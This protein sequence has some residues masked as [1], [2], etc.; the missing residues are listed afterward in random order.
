V[1][2]SSAFIKLLKNEVTDMAIRDIN[3]KPKRRKTWLDQQILY[4]N[5]SGKRGKPVYKKMYYEVCAVCMSS[6]IN[7]DKEQTVCSTCQRLI[8]THGK[9]AVM[10]MR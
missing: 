8:A 10:K 5:K 2:P 3:K 7:K 1:F 9:E 4:T 6:M